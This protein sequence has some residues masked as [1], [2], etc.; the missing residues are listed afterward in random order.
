M[1]PNSILVLPAA[2]SLAAATSILPLTSVHA[3]A[4][5][6]HGAATKTEHAQSGAA[7]S[8]SSIGQAWKVV[9]TG[10]ET[11]SKA[12]SA[13]DLKPIHEATEQMDGAIK[14]LQTAGGISDNDKKMRAD[15]AL[16]QMLGLS[17]ELH[18]AADAGD[19][20]KSAQTLK[21]LQGAMKLVEIQ[22]PADALVAPTNMGD[23]EGMSHGDGHPVSATVATTKVSGKGEEKGSVLPY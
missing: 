1:K 2:F 15:A 18:V 19:A 21:K 22:F 23:M 12:I 16:K 5:H 10:I 11:S 13:G 17:G 20:T 4:G 3:D 6:S 7:G 14:Y 9:T 8:F